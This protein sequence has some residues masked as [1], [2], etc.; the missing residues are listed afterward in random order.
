MSEPPDSAAETSTP[1]GTRMLVRCLRVIGIS[2]NPVEASELKPSDGPPLQPD[3]N[4][5]AELNGDWS[6]SDELKR[7]DDIAKTLLPVSLAG[8]IAASSVAATAGI[9]SFRLVFAGVAVSLMLPAI[10][11]LCSLSVSPLSRR[12]GDLG[13]WAALDHKLWLNVCGIMGLF[14]VVYAGVIVGVV[15]GLT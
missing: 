11:A 14:L 2:V 15:V 13:P 12:A 3:P 7:Q 4:Q 8:T 10:A 6:L 1:R 5:F 9:G